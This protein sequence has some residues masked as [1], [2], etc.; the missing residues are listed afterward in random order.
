M[1]L[2]RIA[3][4]GAG[5]IGKLHVTA[6]QEI[7]QVRVTV[8]CTRHG[9]DGQ[10]LAQKVGADWESDYH[11]AIARDDVDAISICTPS[12]SHKDIAIVAAKAGKHILVEKPIEITLPRIDAMLEAAAEANVK[13][14]CI[15]QSRMR[16][17]ARA[18]KEAINQ[19]RLGK[20][21]FANAIV[22]WHRSPEYYENNWRGTL[23]LDG[24][25][26]LMNQSIHTIDLLQWLA[27]S[28][29]SI[30]AQVET[31]IHTIEG[32][33]TASALVTFSNGAQGMIQ[34]A[35]SLY[36][37]HP[38]RIELHGSKGSIILQEGHLILWKLDN[39]PA[40]EEDRMLNLEQS[41][42]T[43]SQDP[44][45]IGH[46]AHRQQI[47]DFVESILNDT[48]PTIS[49][50]EARKSVEIIRAIYQSSHLNRPIS[51]PYQDN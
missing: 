43:G 7:E 50:A 49:G 14:S 22:P 5:N 11:T 47:T 37:G 9:G 2:V 33:D 8:V 15:F 51:L 3:V 39:A 30:F 45:A 4:I 16:Q 42:G 28:I 29:K 34:G 40:D 12:G 13:L 26:A 10:V 24:G 31:R 27:G 46:R 17:G 41:D 36:Y 19:G 6:M 35:T 48:E 18:V 38:A 32:E 23:E 25:G 44:T 21:L 20:L 1:E